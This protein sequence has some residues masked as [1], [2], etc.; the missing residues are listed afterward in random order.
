[1]SEFIFKEEVRGVG[2]Q[3]FNNPLS[4]LNSD[5]VRYRPT[6]MKLPSW[7]DHNIMTEG[8]DEIASASID[9]SIER[10]S[11]AR[12]KNILRDSDMF[13]N[14][15]KEFNAKELLESF[16]EETT[17]PDVEVVDWMNK[18]AVEHAVLDAWAKEYGRNSSVSINTGDPYY[19]NL[20]IGSYEFPEETGNT[21]ASRGWA[22]LQTPDGNVE[23]PDRSGKAVFNEDNIGLG[24]MS[25]G[26]G[27]GQ[28]HGAIAKFEELA[29]TPIQDSIRFPG[30]KGY[31]SDIWTAPNVF[32]QAPEEE[33]EQQKVS[34]NVSANSE[35]DVKFAFRNPND[36]SQTISENTL[37]VPEGTS[38][39]EFQ[40]AASPAVPPLT[41]EMNPNN[42]GEVQSADS[43]SIQAQ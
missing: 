3:L 17:A 6:R 21:I 36:Y 13:P 35:Q 8:V 22:T 2:E 24:A 19:P 14:A 42:G 39:V 25:S 15:A 40:M 18:S 41:T 5:G 23:V 26:G 1:M 29:E 30:L 32:N 31:G 16:E 9:V 20:E 10:I 34:F 11:E 27:G 12:P 4:R 7:V 37:T 33:S 38:Q 28:G 43:Y